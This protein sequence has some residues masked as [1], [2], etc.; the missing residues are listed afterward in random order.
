[1][2]GGLVTNLGIHML[3]LLLWCFGGVQGACV[4]VSTSTTMTGAFE[5]ERATVEWELSTEKPVQRDMEVW[6]INKDDPGS[7]YDRGAGGLQERVDLSQGFEGLHTRS[8]EKILAGEGFGIEDARPAVELA[9]RL[10]K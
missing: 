10:R 9:H 6:W 7:G 1:M 8:Y 4:E 2:S 3:D 5:L